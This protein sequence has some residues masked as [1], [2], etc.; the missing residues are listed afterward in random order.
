M[1]PNNEKFCYSNIFRVA[2]PSIQLTKIWLYRH[3]S[4]K[5]DSWK[6]PFIVKIVVIDIVH[7]STWRS[8]KCFFNYQKKKSNKFCIKQKKSWKIFALI[9]K[10]RMSNA[11][12]LRL[13]PWNNIR[14]TYHRTL[15]IPMATRLHL[16]QLEFPPFSLKSRSTFHILLLWCNYIHTYIHLQITWEVNKF[17]VSISC[18]FKVSPLPLSVCL[19]DCLYFGRDDNI[20][21]CHNFICAN[22]HENY[23]KTLPS[24]KSRQTTTTQITNGGNNDNNKNK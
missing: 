4:R 11:Y 8:S 16:H 7:S 15:K 24:L 23:T 18:T 5:T 20:I 21:K 22:I 12:Q 14:H 3:K 9:F 10:V 1:K 19:T 17:Y 2:S 13:L 6:M